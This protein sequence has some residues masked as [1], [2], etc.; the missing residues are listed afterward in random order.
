MATSDPIAPAYTAMNRAPHTLHESRTPQDFLSRFEA[1]AGCTVEQ[2]VDRYIAPSAPRALFMVGSLALGMGASGSDIDLVVLVDDRAALLKG[3]SH[4]ANSAR[5]LEFSSQSEVIAGTWLTMYRGILVELSVA[6]T[7]A[8][9][10]VYARLRGRGQELTETE[11]R[12][13][14]RLSSA[15]LLSQSEGYLDR[16]AAILEDPALAIYCSTKTYVSALHEIAKAARAMDNDDVPL[17]LN[18]GRLAVEA[19]YLS[20]FA[21]EGL[22]YLGTKWLAQI[23]YAQG[24]AERVAKYPLL[25]DGVPLLFPQYPADTAQAARYLSAVSQFVT[26]MRG[27]V[28]R[29]I[30]FRIAFQACP[31]IHPL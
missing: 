1:A 26:S 6:L 8:I 24:A 23:G 14:G 27:L 3:D 9:H 20:W 15:W 31:Q 10:E 18:H 11:I 2:V 25:K 22:P 29:K 7:P 19:A 4:I 5:E 17:A 28:E 16:N 21:S 12:I 13:L 30:R